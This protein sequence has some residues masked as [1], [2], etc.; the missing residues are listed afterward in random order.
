[1]SSNGVSKGQK[2]T[3]NHIELRKSR[4]E[5][6]F[7]CWNCEAP[8]TE[9]GACEVC[10]AAPYEGKGW[11][12]ECVECGTVAYGDYGMNVEHDMMMHRIEN[13]QDARFLVMAN[14]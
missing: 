6:E 13:C 5:R 8:T 3:W 9:D 12:I 7:E 4:Q 1:M 2:Q 10:G 11:E 14:V